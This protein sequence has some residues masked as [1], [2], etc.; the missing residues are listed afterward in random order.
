MLL[1]KAVEKCGSWDIVG[2][3]SNNYYGTL[4]DER[5]VKMLLSGGQGEGVQAPTIDK[6]YSVTEMSIKFGAA[7]L[8]EALRI[9]IKRRIDHFVAGLAVNINDEI[10]K[11]KWGEELKNYT[12]IQMRHFTLTPVEASVYASKTMSPKKTVEYVQQELRNALLVKF[13]IAANDPCPVKPPQPEEELE[14]F[15]PEQIDIAAVSLINELIEQVEGD[16]PNRILTRASAYLGN[17]EE[18]LDLF[19]LP[20]PG[21]STTAFQNSAY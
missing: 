8:Q 3:V 6:V 21:Q 20:N 11:G 13:G 2:K 16:V 17:I 15:P 12:D 4:Q 5:V 18:T 9:G 1:V 7:A 10:R 19:R 14:H